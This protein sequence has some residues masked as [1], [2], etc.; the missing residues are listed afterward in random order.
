MFCVKYKGFVIVFMNNRLTIFSKNL[1]F[2]K[3]K[4]RFELNDFNTVLNYI[5]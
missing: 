2:K 4:N 5:E 1:N 3:L